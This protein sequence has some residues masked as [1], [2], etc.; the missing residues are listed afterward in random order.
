MR[1][2][3]HRLEQGGRYID[4]MEIV[5]R[6]QRRGPCFLAQ[7]VYEHGSEIQRVDLYLGGSDPRQTG[8]VFLQRGIG[9]HQPRDEIPQ[10]GQGI[11][12]ALVKR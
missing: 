11:A 4:H 9:L 3:T 7:H 12:I 6:E 1:D 5:E 10:E 2:Q 8:S